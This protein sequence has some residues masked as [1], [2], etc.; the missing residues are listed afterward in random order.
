MVLKE[1]E[2][3]VMEVSSHALEQKRVRRIHFDT[4]VF[5]NLQRDH[6]DYHLTFENY[7]QAKRKLFE[8]LSSLQN[9]KKEPLCRNQCRRCLRPAFS[10]GI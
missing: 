2:F 1:S 10:A 7:F 3:L 6:L 5:T 8:E 4:A 9:E